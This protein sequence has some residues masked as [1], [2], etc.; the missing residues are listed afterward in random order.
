MLRADG[1]GNVAVINRVDDVTVAKVKK[2]RI[3]I[4]FSQTERY[5]DVERPT[6]HEDQEYMVL[7]R[8]QA[9]WLVKELKKKL[10]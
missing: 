3:A 1:T 10:K 8:D 4:G 5:G 2:K 6:E 9:K 7:T